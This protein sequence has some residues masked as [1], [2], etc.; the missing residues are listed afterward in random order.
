MF[1]QSLDSRA[2]GILEDLV[3]HLLLSY[4]ILVLKGVIFQ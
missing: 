4:S 1:T 3:S 2:S